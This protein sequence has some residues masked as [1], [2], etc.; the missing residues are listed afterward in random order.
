MRMS[1]RMRPAKKP[2]L[3]KASTQPHAA[4]PKGHGCS[5]NCGRRARAGTIPEV[6]VPR[7]RCGNPTLAKIAAKIHNV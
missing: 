2:N 1:S 6:E 7:A 4:L 3:D 5:Q